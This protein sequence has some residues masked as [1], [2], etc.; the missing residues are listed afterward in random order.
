MHG[1]LVCLVVGSSISVCVQ[2]P[3][4]LR[5]IL[6]RKFVIK[7]KRTL[8]LTEFL[9]H[10]QASIINAEQMFLLLPNKDWA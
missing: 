5:F 2:F 10:R 1:S 7:R 9:S 4:V 8:Q 3:F 6:K